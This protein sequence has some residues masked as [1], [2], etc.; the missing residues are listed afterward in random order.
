MKLINAD[1]TI[2]TKSRQLQVGKQVQW[3]GV[4]VFQGFSSGI[5]IS[6]Y[7]RNNNRI[8]ALRMRWKW[9]IVGQIWSQIEK[10]VFLDTIEKMA[11]LGCA[12][13]DFY[14]HYSSRDLHVTV[15]R[16]DVISRLALYP[17]NS[18]NSSYAPDNQLCG[19]LK[20]P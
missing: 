20:L 6:E 9:P 8:L 12:L 5:M 10:L 19:V 11:N 17:S 4:L 15:I 16:Q 14:G 18:G 7:A 1:S 3:H 2:A 13:A